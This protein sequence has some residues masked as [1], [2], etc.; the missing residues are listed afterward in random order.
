M[1]TFFLTDVVT[2]E[3]FGDDQAF[4]Y[5]ENGDY[6]N[7]SDHHETI[8]HLT[9]ENPCV[10]AVKAV[11]SFGARSLGLTTSNGYVTNTTW[12]CTDVLE[13]DWFTFFFDDSHWPN[14]VEVWG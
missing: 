6:F 2:V 12:R 1:K 4:L 11:D 9:L 13:D 5:N 8:E 3:L 14:A 10:L 7:G